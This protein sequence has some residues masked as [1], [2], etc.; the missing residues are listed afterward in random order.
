[1]NP[2][3]RP[4]PQRPPTIDATAAARWQA[5]PVVGESP[6]LHEEVA[7]RMAERLDWI[8]RTPARWAHW[9]PARGGWAAHAAL[10]ARYPQATVYVPDQP[11]GSAKSPQVAKKTGAGRWWRRWW[12]GADTPAAAARTVVG[13]VPDAQMDMVWAN[14]LLHQAADPRALIGQWQRALAVDGFLMASCLGPDT[15]RGLRALYAALGWPPPAHEFTDMHDWGD[16]LVAAGF[17]DPVMDM[18]RLTL[19]FDSPERL[20]AELRTLGRN[21]HP[22]RFAALRGRRWHAR[23]CA[24]LREHLAVAEDQGRLALEFEIVY[25]HAFKPLPRAAVA[26]ET[27]ID[28]ADLRAGLRAAPGRGGAS[29]HQG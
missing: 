3:S 18:E 25:A 24:A 14:M 12:P 9:A 26:P 6:W 27:R 17:A 7:R 20:L 2:P 11:A 13:P 19:T 28:L 21:L 4:S 29:G 10:L 22:A 16:M 8:C 23:L 5:L 15:L 1:M